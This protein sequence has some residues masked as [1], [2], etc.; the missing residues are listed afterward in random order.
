MSRA[1]N[2]S[3]LF[4]KTKVKHEEITVTGKTKGD[5]FHIVVDIHTDNIN[6]NTILNQ[7]L[8]ALKKIPRKVENLKIE[9]PGLESA[10]TKALNE[11]RPHIRKRLP[12]EWQGGDSGMSLGAPIYMDFHKPFKD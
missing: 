9:F 6:I 1:E 10:H 8:I 7:I 2:I 4:G 12:K 3:E 11:I 5:T